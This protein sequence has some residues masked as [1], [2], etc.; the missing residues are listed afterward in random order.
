V[1]ALP[2]SIVDQLARGVVLTDGAW[3]TQLQARGLPVGACPDTW[4]LSHPD[5]VEQVP[6]AYVEAGSRVVLTNTFRANRLA[7]ADHGVTDPVEAIN[8]AGVEISRRAAGDRALVFASMG[9][10]G[11]MLL[12]GT[13]TEEELREA[14]TEQAQALAGA[15]ADDFQMPAVTHRRGPFELRSTR[16][17]G[18][19]WD[20]AVE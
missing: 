7:L 6:R 4:N 13:V 15:G 18:R 16:Q 10:S 17:P 5:L 1:P 19:G 9:P 8:R 3:G 2:P 14:F 11:R 20:D 12:A